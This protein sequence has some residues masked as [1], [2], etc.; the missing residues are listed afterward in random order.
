MV[1]DIIFGYSFGDPDLNIEIFFRKEGQQIKGPLIL[2]YRNEVPVAQFCWRLK[3]FS[4]LVFPLFYFFFCSDKKIDL[5]FHPLIIEFL[6]CLS[7]I[8]K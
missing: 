1:I 5:Y 6:I 7:A 4:C 2:K 8:H 3:K